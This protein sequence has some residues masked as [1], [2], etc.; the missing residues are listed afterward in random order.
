L[1]F[2]ELLTAPLLGPELEAETGFKGELWLIDLSRFA[3]VQA[4]ATRFEQD[5]G[6][7]D[8]LVMNAAVG[9]VRAY[10]ASP[11][12]YENRLVATSHPGFILT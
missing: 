1:L 7:L 9:P 12:G 11:E 8:I 3:S 10:H 6:R 5:G 2:N 4:F